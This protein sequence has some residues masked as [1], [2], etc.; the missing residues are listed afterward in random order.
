MSQV[1]VGW[2]AT[3][4]VD[5]T[6]GLFVINKVWLFKINHPFIIR[7]QPFYTPKLMT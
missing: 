6:D 1:L 7:C 5:V 4:V 3:D 2:L